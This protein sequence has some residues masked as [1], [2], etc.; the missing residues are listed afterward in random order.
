MFDEDETLEDETATGGLATP[1][2]AAS[3]QGDPDESMTLD[4]PSLGHSTPHAPHSLRR[5]MQQEDEISDDEEAPRYAGLS[6][7]YETLKDEL[8][9]GPT[10]AKLEP[11]TPGKTQA[12][13]D[14]MGFD[15]SPFVQ[16]TTSKKSHFNHDPLMHRVLDKTFRVQ[17]TPII[18]PRKYKPTGAFTPNTGRRGAPTPRG[19]ASQMLKWDDSSP[20]SSPAPQLRADIFSPIKAPRTPGI[21][22]QTPAKGKAPMSVTHD[23]DYISYSDD[24]D[25]LDFSPPKTIQFHMPQTKLL[26]TPGMC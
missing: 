22:V 16:P 23:D 12:L 26:Q 8:E 15:S 13:P 14:M 21:S 9:G 3:S 25:E 2:R 18:S 24:D 1:T 20:P 11:V 19:A 6:S 4:S 7:P 17:A 5:Q 10:V